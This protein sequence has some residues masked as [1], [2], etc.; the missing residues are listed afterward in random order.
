MVGNGLANLYG[1]AN[2]LVLFDAGWCQPVAGTV[3]N[4]E[5]E[6]Q[7]FVYEVVRA[8]NTTGTIETFSNVWFPCKPED[9][10]FK[11]SVFG[12]PSGNSPCEDSMLLAASKEGSSTASSDFPNRL[13]RVSEALPS[14]VELLQNRPNPFAGETT[15]EYVLPERSMVRI[16]IVDVLGKRI[17]EPVSGIAEA[18][19]YSLALNLTNSANGI[20]VARMYTM[21]ESGTVTVKTIQMILLK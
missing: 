8:R 1:S 4:T 20:Y 2:N 16:E 12:V 14:K 15:L 6:L 19:R 17:Q 5:A 11:Y 9:V 7:T 10:I 13:L 3:T 18:G 21:Q